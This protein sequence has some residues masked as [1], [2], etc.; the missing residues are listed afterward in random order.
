[1]AG[2]HAEALKLQRVTAFGEVIGRS[3]IANTKFAVSMASAP[4]AGIE[5]AEELLAPRRPYVPLDE[6]GKEVVRKK[7][8]ASVKIEQTL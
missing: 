4:A 1:M 5:G 3:G 8:A 6:A 2:E 7:I